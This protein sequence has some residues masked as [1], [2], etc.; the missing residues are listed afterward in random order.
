MIST[1]IV[2]Q[3]Q[4]RSPILSPHPMTISTA[5]DIMNVVTPSM[6]FK[7]QWIIPLLLRKGDEPGRRDGQQLIP[8]RR[9]P[10]YQTPFVMYHMKP[11]KRTLLI[12]LLLYY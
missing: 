7:N 12:P 10:I 4:D 1:A 11:V 6:T 2:D 5:K 8:A 3:S 9:P